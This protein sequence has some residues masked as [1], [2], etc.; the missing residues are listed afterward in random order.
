MNQR[1]YDGD[2]IM[3][4]FPP[5]IIPRHT[6]YWR[7]PLKA[8]PSEE[9]LNSSVQW[10]F[11]IPV[12]WLWIQFW[13]V[14]CHV[15]VTFKQWFL[16]WK[17]S[18]NSDGQQFQ[19]YKQNE[20]SPLTLTHWLQQRKTTTYDVAKHVLAWDWCTNVAGSNPLVRSQALPSWYIWGI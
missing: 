8:G 9:W 4:K 10:T 14:K 3:Y 17:E 20:Q 6:A 13:G 12:L 7:W 2:I 15:R 11:S 1:I 5:C 19:N 16:L 18:L